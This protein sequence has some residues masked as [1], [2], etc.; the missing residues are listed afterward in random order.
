MA[1][2]SGYLD[3]TVRKQVAGEVTISDELATFA[4]IRWH[5][6]W[7]ASPSYLRPP[8]HGVCIGSNIVQKSEVPG[9]FLPVLYHFVPGKTGL[10]R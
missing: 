3:L 5:V 2:L 8:K 1:F 7:N 6:W 9:N 4:A 10:G